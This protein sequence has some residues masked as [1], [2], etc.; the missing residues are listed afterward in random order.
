M[1]SAVAGHPDCPI[2]VVQSP[3][4]NHATVVVVN[5]VVAILLLVIAIAFA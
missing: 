4:Y 5:T 2:V 3:S 1:C